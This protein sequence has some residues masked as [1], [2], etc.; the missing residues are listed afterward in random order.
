MKVFTVFGWVE[1]LRPLKLVRGLQ[2]RFTLL[3]QPFK[4]FLSKGILILEEA[5]PCLLVRKPRDDILN[6]GIFCSHYQGLDGC[7]KVATPKSQFPSSDLVLIPSLPYLT[8]AN[9][10][11]AF[12]GAALLVWG[13]GLKIRVYLKC[14]D[15]N[16]QKVSRTS[17]RRNV[18]INPSQAQSAH[19]AHLVSQAVNLHDEPDGTGRKANVQRLQ[20]LSNPSADPWRTT[21][22]PGAARRSQA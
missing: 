20:P 6:A 14:L 22:Q 15:R 7:W 5:R 18:Q 17:H 12:L 10:S 4:W 1:P 3:Q 2:L 16:D 21:V 9:W 11:G 13:G 19:L 8:C